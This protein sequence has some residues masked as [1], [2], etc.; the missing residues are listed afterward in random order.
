M[1]IIALTTCHNRRILTLSVLH[2]LHRQLLPP[3]CSLEICLVDDGSND[4]TGDD[5]RTNFPYVTV[6]KGT[7]NLFW[8]GGMRFGWECFVK[9]QKFDYLLVFNDDIVLESQSIKKL[10]SAAKIVENSGC[11]MF[12]VSGAFKDSISGNVTYGGV[13]R[14]SFWHPLRFRYLQPTNAI[15]DCDTLNMNFA[16][17]SAGALKRS[18]FLSKGFTHAKADFDFGL[19]LRADG[20]RVVLAPTYMGVCNRNP[21]KGS[22]DEPYITFKEK[23]SRFTSV[24]EL[25]PR[26]WALFSRQH[27]GLLWPLF[28]LMPYVRVYVKCAAL[29]LIAMVKKSANRLRLP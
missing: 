16:L 26:E 15:Q 5:V 11:K 9:H 28:W 10:L 8:A 14:R 22:S 18:G 13:V 12:A 20:G 17:I 21:I 24:K 3:G 27:A 25:A 23:W 1:K 29:S 19:R 4:F 6:L 7:G 2:A